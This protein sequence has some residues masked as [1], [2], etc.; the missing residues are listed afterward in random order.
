MGIS[1]QCWCIAD[2]FWTSLPHTPSYLVGTA[3]INV[4]V[5]LPQIGLRSLG[6]VDL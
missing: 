5:Q 3:L 4:N 1:V 6:P 2:P